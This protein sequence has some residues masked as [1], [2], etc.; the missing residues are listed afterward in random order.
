M[1]FH[2]A[3]LTGLL[4]TETYARA[5]IRAGNLGASGEEIERDVT[6]RMERRQ[7]PTRERPPYCWPRQH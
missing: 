7:I 3:Y 6:A 1:S 5:I 4:Q 2:G